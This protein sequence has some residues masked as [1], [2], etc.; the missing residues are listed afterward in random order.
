VTGKAREHAREMLRTHL[1]LP[2]EPSPTDKMPALTAKDVLA[3]AKLAAGVATKE[4]PQAARQAVKGASPEVGGPPAKGPSPE[5]G[6]SPGKGST[7]AGMPGAQGATSAGQSAAPPAK[8][9]TQPAKAE[10]AAGRPEPAASRPESPAGKKP[11][12]DNVIDL[13]TKAAARPGGKRR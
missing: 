3:K 1:D 9:E 11:A 13:S 10:A 7:P 12:P 6:G 4:S 2:P 8:G 5:L